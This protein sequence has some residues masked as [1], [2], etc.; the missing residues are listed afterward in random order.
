MTRKAPLLFDAFPALA[1]S[2]PWLPLAEFAR[3]AQSAKVN[4]DQFR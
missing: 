4:L 2:V 1:K 3:L